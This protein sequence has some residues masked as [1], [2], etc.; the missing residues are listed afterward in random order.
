MRTELALLAV[1]CALAGGC[2]TRSA[3]VEHRM[4]LPQAGPRH[5]VE[6]TQFFVM[7]VTLAAPEP[8][9]PP[10]AAGAGA[11]EVTVCAEVWLSADGD[12]TRVAPFD[13]APECVATTAS[14]SR[15]Y[16]DSVAEALRRWAFTPAM[17]CEFPPE[18]LDRR[19]EGDCTGPDVA[20]RRVPVRLDFAFTFSSR[21]GE[22]RV[23]VSRKVAR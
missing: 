4:L 10:V 2:A 3:S 5:A 9:F 8:V 14:Q 13:G 19:A 17:I 16:A 12:I 22:R 7:P 6:S 18:L 23:G 11:V 1:A 15:A 21:D 20:V